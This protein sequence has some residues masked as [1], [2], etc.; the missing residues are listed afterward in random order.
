MFL[1]HRRLRA[2]DIVEL[3]KCLLGP[4]FGPQQLDIIGQAR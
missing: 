1:E 4:E 3:I 2:G